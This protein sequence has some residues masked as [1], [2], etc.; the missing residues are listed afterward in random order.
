MVLQS[1]GH[2]FGLVV[3]EVHD[4]EEIVVKPVGALLKG[5]PA[6][7]GTTIL[8]NGSVALILDIAGLAVMSGVAAKLRERQPVEDAPA[9]PVAN[10]DEKSLLLFHM[11]GAEHMAIPLELVTRLE[12]FPLTRI[13]RSGGREV[14]QYD[15]GIM[16]LVRVTD[17]VEG[18]P[19]MVDSS[20]TLDV[21]EH[22]AKQQ[23]VGLVVGQIKDIV[24][25]TL[26]VTDATRQRGLLGSTVVNQQITGVL[27]VPAILR[28]ARPE[29][30]TPK[31]M[32][33]VAAKN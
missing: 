26:R 8:G 7:A 29:D 14:V 27:D 5:I 12:K 2:R 30:A 22:H 23:P 11:G 20:D 15:G 4:T 16:P 3:D 13:E 19:P 9:L 21:V 1:E 10:P 28:A 6:F 33:I 24:T 32:P 18:C 17:F 25:A 31:L